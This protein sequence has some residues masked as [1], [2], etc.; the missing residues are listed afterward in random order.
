SHQA[1]ATEAA[2][3]ISD[4]VAK[5]SAAAPQG[6]PWWMPTWPVTLGFGLYAMSFWVLFVL[7]PPQGQGPSEL[8]KTL[9]GAVVI[10]AFINGVVAAVYTAS[11]D[12]QKKNDT[13][14]A[15]AHAIARQASSTTDAN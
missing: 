14:A 6:V 2:K 7:A 9:A 13:I 3:M 1:A 11:R 10:T 15:Q 5:K 8:F 4:A 12:S